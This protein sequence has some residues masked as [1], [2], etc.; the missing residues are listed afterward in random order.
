MIKIKP[1]E[2]KIIIHDKLNLAV[3]FDIIYFLFT[4]AVL[5]LQQLWWQKQ[6][7]KRRNEVSFYNN[8][9]YLASYPRAKPSSTKGAG[10]SEAVRHGGGRRTK[11]LQGEREKEK[12]GGKKEKRGERKE[13][14]ER[15]GEESKRLRKMY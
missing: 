7:S 5:S 15:K 3:I 4:F 9:N 8:T 10:P 6:R 13:K 14:K 2:T 1:S 11:N 12:K